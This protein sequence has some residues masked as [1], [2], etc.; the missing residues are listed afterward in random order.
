MKFE[1]KDTIKAYSS[2][3][4]CHHCG[5][6]FGCGKDDDACWCQQLPAL[7]SDLLVRDAK[8]LCPDCLSDLATPTDSA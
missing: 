8:C 6:R 4:I 3:T 1:L 7:S 5:R 2:L